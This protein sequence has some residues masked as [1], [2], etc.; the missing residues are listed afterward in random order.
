MCGGME[1]ESRSLRPIFFYFTLTIYRTDSASSNNTQFCIDPQSIDGRG[2]VASYV[3]NN[4]NNIYIYIMM[5][6]TCTRA[7]ATPL[8]RYKTTTFPKRFSGVI[9]KY[10]K[11]KK[12]KI[13]IVTR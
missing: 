7:Y 3:M 6:C 12:I 4:N 1:I 13:T 11:K 9:R 8:R 10:L 5:M 2:R